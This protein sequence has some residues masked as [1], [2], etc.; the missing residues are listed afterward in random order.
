MYK[1]VIIMI[2]TKYIQRFLFIYLTSRWIARM[3]VVCISIS[4]IVIVFVF[5]IVKH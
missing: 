3:L 2:M 4:V 1:K 5:V